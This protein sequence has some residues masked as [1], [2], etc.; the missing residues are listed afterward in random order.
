MFGSHNY[1]LETNDD[2]EVPF[3]FKENETSQKLIALKFTL[4]VTHYLDK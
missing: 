1:L 2:D 3:Q 4:I